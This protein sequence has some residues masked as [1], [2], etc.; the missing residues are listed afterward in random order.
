MLLE[1]NGLKYQWIDNWIIVPDT[2]TSRADGRTHGVAV[3]RT[4]DVFIFH[5]ADPAVLR[6]DAHGKLKA[7]W[8]SDFPGAHGLTLVEEDGE[9]RLWLVDSK[10]GKVVKTTLDGEELLELKRPD[11]KAY[12]EGAAYSPTWVAVNEQ[13]FGGNGDV[14]LTDGYGSNLIHRYDATGK[15]IQS[16]TGQ[17]GGGGPFKCPHGISFRFDKAGNELVIADRGNCQVQVYDAEGDF[18]HAFGK[19]VL[20]SP[21][22]VAYHGDRLVIPELLARIAILEP[23]GSLVGYLGENPDPRRL[24]G[25]PNVAKSDIESGKFNSPHSLAVDPQGNLYIVE[26]IIGG[27]VTK[28]IEK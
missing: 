16:I 26:W 15:Y 7:S 20:N 25:W 2:P 22:V 11:H 23:D 17:E 6:Y 19:D 13:R 9:E 14:W 21:C 24:E 18:K 5:Q 1:T 10:T 3:S 8:G 28:L 4:G 12:A 27:R